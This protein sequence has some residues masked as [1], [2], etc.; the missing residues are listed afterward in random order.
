MIAP[1]EAGM[2]PLAKSERIRP[3]RA[4]RTLKARRART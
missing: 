4:K 1:A 2:I 3:P